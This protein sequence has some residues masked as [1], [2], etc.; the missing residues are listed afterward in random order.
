MLFRSL[1]FPAGAE[2]VVEGVIRPDAMQAEGPFGE[3]TG[4]YGPAEQ[5]PVI[6]VTAITHRRNPIF[7]AGLTGVPTTDNHVLK[8]FAYES[9][10]YEDLHRTF[11]E[12]TAVAFPDW[13][14]TQ[15]VAIVAVRQRYKGQARHLLLAAL[16][17]ASRPKWVIVVD[18]DIDVHDTERVLWAMVT[19]G[20]PA[21]DIVTVDRV[22]G[23]PLD[24]SA[25]EKEL[26]SVLGF[27]ATRPFGRPFPEVVEVPGADEFRLD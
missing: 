18:D 26:I 8:A 12:V 7:L 22:A 27:D 9:T 25:P 4:Y 20:Q 3:F 14:G 21:E 1:L 13:G 6:E 15:Y 11:P 17:H 2:F 5:N 16:G 23:G 24:P 10:L 19:R